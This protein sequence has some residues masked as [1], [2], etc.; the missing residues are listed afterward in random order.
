[1]KNSFRY[2]FGPVYS[3]RLGVSLGID[4]VSDK[5]KLCNFD[6]VYCQLGDTPV[7]TVERKVYVPTAEVV[8]E[9]KDL[10]DVQIDHLTFSGRG[11]PT[12]AANLGEMIRALRKIR[13]EKIAVITNSSLMDHEDVRQDLAL[14]D[15]I[16]AKLDVCD[17]YSLGQ[18]NR[19]VHKVDFRNIVAGIQIFR[20]RFKGK[21]ALQLMF[22][23]DNKPFARQLAELAR[24]I[25]A[26]EVQINTPLRPSAVRPLT[27]EELDEIK[28]CFSG[29]PAVTVYE[30]ERKSYIPLNEAATK[31]RHGNYRVPR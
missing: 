14:A 27:R 8:E 2:I 3:W 5:S 30:K 20:K 1:M 12:L 23:E 4:P 6:C 28:I 17:Q 16:L 9:I 13:R 24:S 7:L 10:P 31:K 18:I 11:E 29:L 26:D 25:N 21:L 15:Y 22:I 19:A